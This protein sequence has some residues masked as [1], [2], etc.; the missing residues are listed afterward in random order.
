MSETNRGGAAIAGVVLL[1]AAV[2]GFLYLR[3]ARERPAPAPAAA[4]API[5][6]PVA[7]V[8][9]P[10]APSHPIEDAIVDAPAIGGDVPALPSLPDS[11]AAAIEALLDLLAG[12]AIPAWLVP[13]YVIQRTVATIDNL[14]RAKIASNISVA[15]ATPGALAIEGDGETRTL[16]AANHARYA[17]QVDAFESADTAALVAGYVRLYP[18]FQQAYR[19]LGQPDAY[20]NDRLI[21]VIDHLLAAPDVAPPLA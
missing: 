2:G 3:E 9:A 21:E 14:P 10:A 7:A 16:S 12:D 20:F 13:E 4:T 17:A 8:E 19:E 11:D 15:R 1:A 5:E 18:L 6:A